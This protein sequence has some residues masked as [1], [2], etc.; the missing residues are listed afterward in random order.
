MAALSLASCLWPRKKA[1]PPPADPRSRT[2]SPARTLAFNELAAATSNFRDDLRIVREASLYKAYLK[3]VNQVVAIKLQRDRSSSEQLNKEFLARVLTLSSLRHPNVV[4]HVGFCADGHHRVLVHEYM[5]LSSL[6]N[7]LHDRSPGK[8]LLDWN[9]RMKIAAG[10]AKGLEYLH[11]KGVVY[12]KSMSSSDLLLGDG[13]HPKLSQYGLAELHQLLVAEEDEGLCTTVFTRS[14][15]II[16]PEMLFTGRVTTKS[17]VYSFG[18]VLLELITGRRPFDPAQAVAKD[19]DL[20][21]WDRSQFRWMADPA[22]QDR[23]PPMDLHEALRVASMCIHQKPAMRSPIGAVAA[24]LSRL[25]DHPPESSHHS[26][27]H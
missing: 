22:L 15:N 5:T 16:A 1:P 8:A 21:I 7:H 10:V 24:A 2:P 14:G 19:R 9:T 17:N 3:S 25:A 6:Q 18:G 20:V 4:N 12:S 26:A 13:Y 23:Y 27:P 11:G